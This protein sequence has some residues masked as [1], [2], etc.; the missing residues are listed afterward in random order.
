MARP[1]GAFPGREGCSRASSRS[2]PFRPC[3]VCS[4]SLPRQS[5]PSQSHVVSPPNLIPTRLMARAGW[6]PMMVAI[7]RCLMLI[8][9]MSKAIVMRSFDRR[10]VFLAAGIYR[11][12]THPSELDCWSRFIFV[13][14]SGLRG[15]RAEGDGSN[16]ALN[17]H[18]PFGHSSARPQVSNLRAQ[19]FPA[20]C[21]APAPAEDANIG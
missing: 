7:V 1:G 16:A 11:N 10:A 13:S 5:C 14:S 21:V 2:L 12:Q 6:I 17:V 20:Q 8:L 19:H 4:P 18:K 3:V 9:V 15:A